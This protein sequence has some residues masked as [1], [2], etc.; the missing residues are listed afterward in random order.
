MWEH[1]KELL[2]HGYSTSCRIKGR[3]SFNKGYVQLPC[4]ACIFTCICATMETM[5]NSGFR[6][7]LKD[8]P[9]VAKDYEQLKFNSWKV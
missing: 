6:D 5:M 8:H 9:A 2:E 3:M 7:Y 4:G 1:Q